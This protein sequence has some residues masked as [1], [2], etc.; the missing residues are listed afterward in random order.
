MPRRNLAEGMQP[1]VATVAALVDSLCGSNCFRFTPTFHLRLQSENEDQKADSALMPA[2][3]RDTNRR[4]H[5]PQLG[6]YRYIGKLDSA[7]SCD[8]V[9]AE[10]QIRYCGPPFLDRSCGRDLQ[11]HLSVICG[12]REITRARIFTSLAYTTTV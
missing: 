11:H 5:L 6:T 12:Q 2:A 8:V 3:E 1:E 9:S 7:V 4:L 10:M